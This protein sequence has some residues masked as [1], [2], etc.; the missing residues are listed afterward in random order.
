M[1][2]SILK[3]GMW[4]LVAFVTTIISL[5]CSKEEIKEAL[6]GKKTEVSVY[7]KDTDGTPLNGWVVYAF[8]EFAWKSES[9]FHAKQ[10][11]TENEGKAIFL[12]DDLDIK[13]EQEVYR[14]V[15][16]Y[17]KS[18]KNIFGQEITKESLKKVVPVTLKQG[19]NKT[20]EIKL[21]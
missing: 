11:A 15:V 1:R 3:K 16:Y 14:F 6:E 10:S 4:L 17:T 18:K 7:L 2:K 19:E 21:D 8:N 20:V 13:D 12:L 5:S 9:T